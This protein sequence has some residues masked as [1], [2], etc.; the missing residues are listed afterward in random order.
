MQNSVVMHLVPHM[1]HSNFGSLL[2]GKAILTF[3]RL[4]CVLT[5]SCVD[6]CLCLKLVDIG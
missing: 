5:L 3:G 2:P 1:V 6:L 4:F